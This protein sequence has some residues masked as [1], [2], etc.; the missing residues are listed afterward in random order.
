MVIF[1]RE[2]K[3]FIVIF[4]FGMDIREEEFV[5]DGDKEKL[6]WILINL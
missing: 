6:V 2:E 1:F 3:R 5:I 4:I